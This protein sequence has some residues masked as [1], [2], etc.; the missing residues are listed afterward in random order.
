MRGGGAVRKSLKPVRKCGKCPL[1]QGDFCWGFAY[2]R[3]VWRKGACPAFGNEAAQ[4]LFYSWEKDPP[5]KTRR[6]IRRESFPG[7][8]N[9]PCTG[10][11]E[12]RKG[13]EW[14]RMVMISAARRRKDE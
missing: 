10:N 1:N 6:Q 7:G 9:L 12:G 8:R 11:L 4:G 13:A 14:R 5:V 3:G 2:P